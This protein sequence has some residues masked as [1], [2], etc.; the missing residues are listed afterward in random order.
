MVQFVVTTCKT[1]I[2]GI[3]WVVGRFMLSVYM[4]CADDESIGC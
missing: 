3:I 4:Y 1:Y 2:C